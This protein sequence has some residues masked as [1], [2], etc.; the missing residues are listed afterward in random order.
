M[1][2]IPTPVRAIGDASL[3]AAVD[4]RLAEEAE[5]KVRAAREAA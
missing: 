3:T 2:E 4:K 5:A 1:D